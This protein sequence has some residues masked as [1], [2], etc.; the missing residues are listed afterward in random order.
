MI[1]ASQEGEG[2]EITLVRIWLRTY[3]QEKISFPGYIWTLGGLCLVSVIKTSCTVTDTARD[4]HFEVGIP[5]YQGFEA[6]QAHVTRQH[7]GNYHIDKI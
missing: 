7:Q 6:E 5:Q 2:G 1:R 4:V 3:N